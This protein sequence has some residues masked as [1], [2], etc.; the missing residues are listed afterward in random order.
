MDQVGEDLDW[1]QGGHSGCSCLGVSG[2][3]DGGERDTGSSTSPLSEARAGT[4]VLMDTSQIRFH[5]ATVGTPIPFLMLA[6]VI[7]YPKRLNIVC[8]AVQQDLIA[9]PL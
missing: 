3:G 5:C 4:Q 6:S 2:P 7:F 8:C 1:K 9:Y